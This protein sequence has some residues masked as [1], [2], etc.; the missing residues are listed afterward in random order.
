M[1]SLRCGQHPPPRPEEGQAESPVS[2]QELHRHGTGLTEPG[3][4]WTQRQ[5]QT[6]EDRQTRTDEDKQ[7]RVDRQMRTDRDRQTR[8]DRR[9]QM[10][11]DRQGQ[12]QTGT[13]RDRQTDR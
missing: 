5:G 9:G 6:D 12:R 10:R 1:A 7:T 4:G 8:I 2:V 13:D 11:I 3:T